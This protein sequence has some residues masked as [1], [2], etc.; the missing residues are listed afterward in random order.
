MTRITF[1]LIVSIFIIFSSCLQVKNHFNGMAPGKWRGVLYLEDN[2]VIPNPKGLPQED[3]LNL[4]FEEVSGGEL[5]FNFDVVYDSE[6]SFHINIFNGAEKI[7][8]KDI[9]WGRSLQTADDTIEIHFPEYGNYIKGSFKENVLDGVF[10]IPSKNFLHIPFSARYGVDYRFTALK[11]EPTQNLTGNWQTKFDD[12]EEPFDAIGE[13]QQT[14]NKLLGTFRTETGDFRYLEGTVQKNKFYLSCFDGAHSFLIEGKILDK[15][16]IVGTFK[17][18][19]T[20]KTTFTSKRSNT[21]SLKDPNAMTK[22]IGNENM[23][24]TLKNPEGKTI[25]LNNPEYK[26]KGKV[27]QI[28]GTWCP[29]CKDETIFL[30]EFAEKNPNIAVIGLAFERGN[31]IAEANKT[32]TKYK[33]VMQVPYELV[34]AGK[35][36]KVIVTKIFPQLDKIYSFPTTI[37]VDKNNKIQGIYTGFNGPATSQYDSYKKEFDLKAKSL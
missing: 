24:F 20:Y 9:K 26:G 4:K 13:F 1:T 29:N 31:D 34:Y 30:K 8:L 14:G 3:K 2:T 21:P 16:N 12:A 37:F 15:D 25:N 7:E 10:I 5:P 32:L 23:N 36:D 35:A 11:K 27:I 28:L 17:S 19:L 22:N 33:K 18:G 6:D